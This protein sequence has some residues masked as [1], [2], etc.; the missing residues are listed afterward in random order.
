MFGKMTTS[1]TTMRDSLA[2]KRARV[3][4]RG[5]KEVVQESVGRIRGEIRS[6]DELLFLVR[7][8]AWTG[9]TQRKTDEP[10][11]LARATGDDA[12][13]YEIFVGTDSARTFARRLSRDTDCWLIRGRGMILH[14][15]WT[16]SGAAWTGEIRRFFV[17]PPQA[18]Y[19]YESFT[20]PDARGLG[21]YPMALS[22]IGDALAADGIERLFVGVEVDNTPSLRAITKAGFQPAFSVTFHRRFGRLTV[23]EATGPLAELA[24]D[25]LQP[26]A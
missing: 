21:L 13:D 9:K 16:T 26:N 18:A 17:A 8:A 20:R 3:R 10:L 4:A 1:V 23:D 12:D 15:T 2:K 25:I 24:R 7:D 22:G 5:I 6:D 11:R 19:I 14:A